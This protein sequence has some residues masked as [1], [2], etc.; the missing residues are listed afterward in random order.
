MRGVSAAAFGALSF[1]KRSIPVQKS[2]F[3]YGAHRKEWLDRLLPEDPTLKPQEAVLYI[4]GG[5]WIAGNKRYYPAD[6]QFLC[7]VGY[8]VF[9]LGYPLAP[10]HPHPLLLQSILKAVAWI[11][12]HH[13]KISRVHMM[14]DSA[15]AN[16]AAMYGVL[17]SNPE[18]LPC[19]G[20]DFLPDDLLCPASVVSIYGLLERETLLGDDPAQVKPVVR[21]FLQ[22]YGGPEVL[23][24]GPIA[25]ENAITPMDLAWKNHPPCFLGGGD[26]DFLCGSS[27]FYAQELESR[28]IPV[29]RKIYPQAQHGF[30][31]MRH[32]QTPVLKQ[33]VLQ[34]LAA[35]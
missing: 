19:V 14:G 12:Q 24:P 8:A 33:D 28:G 30:L 3:S 35:Y 11:K 7:N 5:G 25:P 6:L 10:E 32:E 2:E 22:S 9:N 20:S 27:D 1:R 16:L 4:H 31:N 15:G 34:F 29:E 23:Q 17:Y 21:L 18:L 26:I 13:P